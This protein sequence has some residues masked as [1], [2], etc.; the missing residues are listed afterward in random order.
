MLNTRKLIPFALAA[1]MMAGTA[2]AQDSS[3]HDDFEYIPPVD[4]YACE[5]WRVPT[6]GGVR[7]VTRDCT[8]NT[9]RVLGLN[10]AVNE[11]DWAA[12]YDF[13]MALQYNGVSEDDVVAKTAQAGF[14]MGNL[15][16]AE[17][18]ARIASE[19]E[20]R[21]PYVAMINAI[22]AVKDGDLEEAKAVLE[23]VPQKDGD[24]ATIFVQQ[25][26]YML[27]KL[28]YQDGQQLDKAPKIVDT[29]AEK[30]LWTAVRA[31]QED[32]QGQIDVLIANDSS[33]DY[34]A[35]AAREIKMMRHMS[36]LSLSPGYAPA[37]QG[38]GAIYGS[39]G[40]KNVI[41]P[42]PVPGAPAP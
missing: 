40:K 15:S 18:A 6:K 22:L 34:Y 28:E 36:E 25:T 13:G 38:M 37:I 1:G 31:A 16:A 4:Q 33:N 29:K 7:I 42:G 2:A 17:E 27:A 9:A 21:T 20:I 5:Q 24:P 41:L 19:M 3:A 32:L 39:M 35:A 23:D 30:Y 14:M 26:L 10:H 12:A 8:G 11:M